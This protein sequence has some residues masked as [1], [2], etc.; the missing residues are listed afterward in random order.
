[1]T[2]KKKKKKKRKSHHYLNSV[3][4][5]QIAAQSAVTSNTKKQPTGPTDT[6]SCDAY[7]HAQ[8]K[9]IDSWYQGKENQEG[10]RMALPESDRLGS[11]SEDLTEELQE[12]WE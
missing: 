7:T 10:I 8:G 4:V 6:H 12:P 1:M 9:G 2:H 11:S 3:T 5:P